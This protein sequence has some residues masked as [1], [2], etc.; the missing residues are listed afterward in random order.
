[1]ISCGTASECEPDAGEVDLLIGAVAGRGA[2]VELR[3]F[4][5]DGPF[6]VRVEIPVHTD[7]GRSRLAGSGGGI[8][9][10]IRPATEGVRV[11]RE[12]VQAGNQLPRAT[13]RLADV[14]V[15]A[16]RRVA[17]AFFLARQQPRELKL[18]C[19]VVERVGARD[20]TVG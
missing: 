20:R 11:D 10:G 2:A 8:G 9:E 13:A 15:R 4:V 1:M 14:E 3:L 17:E 12:L 19:F 16:R 18:P 5:I 7:C 6:Y